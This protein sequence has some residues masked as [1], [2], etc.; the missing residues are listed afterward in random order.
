VAR[1]V[2]NVSLGL[3]VPVVAGC[4]PPE[5]GSVKLSDELTPGAKSAYGP[6]GAEAGT[7]LLGPGQFR[8]APKTR[9]GRRRRG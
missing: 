7:R 1:F 5:L 8:V 3:G 4:D 6:V 9:P 2:L